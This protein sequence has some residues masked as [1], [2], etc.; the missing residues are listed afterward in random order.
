METRDRLKEIAAKSPEV[1]SAY[2]SQRNSV[3]KEVRHSI[4]DY[5]EGLIEKNKGDPKNM[6]KTINRVLDRDIKST[7]VSSIEIDGKMLT[8]KPVVLE[9]FIIILS[10]LDQSSQVA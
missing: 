3:T 6:W 9:M 10:R 7:A 8:K 2:P 5:Y 4:R 1:W